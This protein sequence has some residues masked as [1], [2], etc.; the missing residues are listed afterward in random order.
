MSNISNFFNNKYPYTDFHE[1]NIDQW[2]LKVMDH[3]TRITSLEEWKTQ[4]IAE[5]QALLATV[6]SM[7]DRVAALEAWKITHEAAYESLAATVAAHTSQISDLG[8]RMTTAETKN[9]QQDAQIASLQTGLAQAINDSIQRDTQLDQR[10]I[11]L[12]TQAGG[13]GIVFMNENIIAYAQDFRFIDELSAMYG[14]STAN[15]FWYVFEDLDDFTSSGFVTGRDCYIYLGNISAFDFPLT[16]SIKRGSSVYHGSFANSS[17]SVTINGIVCTIESSAQGSWLKLDT[18]AGDNITGLKLENGLVNTPFNENTFSEYM[19]VFRNIVKDV[20]DQN[21][22][23]TER[24]TIS[25]LSAKLYVW[26]R[27]DYPSGTPTVTTIGDATINYQITNSV[28]M[29]QITVIGDPTLVIDASDT[30]KVYQIH[31]E[32][33]GIDELPISSLQTNVSWERTMVGSSVIRYPGAINAFYQRLTDGNAEVD[34]LTGNLVGILPAKG[35]DTTILSFGISYPL[36]GN[37]SS[38]DETSF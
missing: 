22:F 11:D 9:T 1:L 3:E 31:I 23:N 14:E 28:V 20:I 17:S 16:L 7:N 13:D 2:I 32:G 15:P 19:K 10:L 33:D 30:T 29:G 34:F 4:H 8:G 25:G 21:I 5:Y 6:N 26:N 35:F 24:I 12:I 37:I 38:L 18:N 27:E 36:P